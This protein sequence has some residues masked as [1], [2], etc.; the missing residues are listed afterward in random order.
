[1]TATS[2]GREGPGSRH[3]T[4]LISTADGGEAPAP[5]PPSF[6]EDPNGALAVIAQFEQRVD[7]HRVRYLN[8]LVAALSRAD[9]DIAAGVSFS[10]ARRTPVV[11]GA[12]ESLRSAAESRHDAYR[13]EVEREIDELDQL[14]AQAQAQP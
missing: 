14:V 5:L 10:S 4:T 7:Q 9:A 12:I 8:E 2:V 3:G 6:L 1:V 11:A 13:R